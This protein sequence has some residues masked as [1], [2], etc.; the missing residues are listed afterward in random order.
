MWWFFIV[1]ANIIIERHFLIFCQK[2]FSIL[3]LFIHTMHGN[4]L[5]ISIQSFM[6]NFF[7]RCFLAT[8]RGTREHFIRCHGKGNKDKRKS[9]FVVWN[10]CIKETKFIDS[11]LP[12]FPLKYS[13]SKT[14][15]TKWEN[16]ENHVI[17]F[18][19]NDHKM[20][21]TPRTNNER[22]FLKR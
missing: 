7:I 14:R 18:Q 2:I 1:I 13:P 19:A 12:I 6:Y 4:L 16:I 8:T 20:F 10:T 3:P 15:E 21:F 17:Y 22:A 5:L 11:N 9:S